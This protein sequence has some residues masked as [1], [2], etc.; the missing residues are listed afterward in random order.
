[1]GIDQFELLNG[2]L[3]LDLTFVIVSVRGVMGEQRAGHR[4]N[5]AYDTQGDRESVPHVLPLL[6]YPF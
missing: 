2:P 4:Y 3:H 5:A 6:E 1:M